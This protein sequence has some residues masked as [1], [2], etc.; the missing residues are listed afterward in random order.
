MPTLSEGKNDRSARKYHTLLKLNE[1]L[2]SAHNWKDICNT[3]QSF[4]EKSTVLFKNSFFCLSD[5]PWEC[6]L[7]LPPP[8]RQIEPLIDPYLFNVRPFFAHL[9]SIE[10][11]K[12]NPLQVHHHHRPAVAAF[13]ANG[14]HIFFHD[15]PGISSFCL[16]MARLKQLLIKNSIHFLLGVFLNLPKLPLQ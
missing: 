9:N 2:T 3:M 4:C 16:C 6:V 15:Y 8:F 5:E 12:E 11:H 13:I 1:I 7:L 10:F 14:Y